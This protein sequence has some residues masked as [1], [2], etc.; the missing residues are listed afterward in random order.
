MIEHFIHAF[1]MHIENIYIYQEHGRLICLKLYRTQRD[2]SWARTGA[3]INL[4]TLNMWV[5]LE[6][7]Y[8]CVYVCWP[9]Y[10]WCEQYVSKIWVD[11]YVKYVQLIWMRC[12]CC[13]WC[14]QCVIL[15]PTWWK[16]LT[17]VHVER[18]AIT[19]TMKKWWL[20]HA[21]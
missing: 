2:K 5:T 20:L 1:H 15:E 4:A 11:M 9:M 18:Y 10:N 6:H 3:V 12:I 17:V 13:K 8:I 14:E 21:W 19:M 7:I 16:M